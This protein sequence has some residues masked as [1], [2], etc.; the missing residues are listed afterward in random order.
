[1]VSA[2]GDENGVYNIDLVLNFG[3]WSEF[4]I[5]MSVYENYFLNV[6]IKIHLLFYQQI[7]PDDL[8]TVNLSH[9]F[10]DFLFKYHDGDDNNADDDEWNLQSHLHKLTC[11]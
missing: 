3:S 1:M 7:F 6:L 11:P 9:K 2:L 8:G 4:F 5:F 10:I